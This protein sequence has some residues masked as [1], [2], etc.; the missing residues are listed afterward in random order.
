MQ[1][2][3]VVEYFYINVLVPLLSKGSEYIFH[4]CTHSKWNC[5]QIHTAHAFN[6]AGSFYSVGL[7]VWHW[8]SLH[9][10][11]VYK[12]NT[13]PW[14]AS[15]HSSHPLPFPASA[16]ITAS[17]CH[18]TMFNPALNQPWRIHTKI[19]H[20]R[21][22]HLTFVFAICLSA[23]MCESVQLKNSDGDR[24]PSSWVDKLCIKK[25]SGR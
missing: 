18:Q 20:L 21:F 11:H 7:I 15:P 2:L 3:L 22:I 24:V 16:I 8:F 25:V 1:D 5:S 10:H 17:K 14:S 6:T 12:P 13:P 19:Y 23:C 9:C 4:H